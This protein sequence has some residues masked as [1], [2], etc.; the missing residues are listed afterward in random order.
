MPSIYEVQGEFDLITIIHT[1]EH[2]A[3]PPEFMR[4][5][6]KHLA[7]GGALIIEV[8]NRRA[9][10]VA[11]SAPEHIIAY[12]IGSVK[13]TVEMCR[14]ASRGSVLPGTYPGKPTRFEFDNDRHERS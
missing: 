14:I 6:A 12:E 9:W 13:Y 4:E 5:V 2:I 8:P 3:K 1:L 10:M 7:P 11:Y